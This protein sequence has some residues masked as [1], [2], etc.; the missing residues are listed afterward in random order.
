MIFVNSKCILQCDEKEEEVHNQEINDFIER[1][2]DLPNYECAAL[3]KRIDSISENGEVKIKPC[4]LHDC[5]EMIE[6]VDCKNGVD[7]FEKEGFI[8]FFVY[9]QGYVKNYIYS[10]LTHMIQIRPFNK[11]REYVNVFRQIEESS[12]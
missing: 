9:G 8:T 5:Y 4:S 12:I 10:Y 11:E 2:Y 3:I 7:L 6:Y 1:L